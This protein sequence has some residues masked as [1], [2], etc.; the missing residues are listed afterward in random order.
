MRGPRAE[1]PPLIRVLLGNLQMERAHIEF[2][3]KFY[4]VN[5]QDDGV[6][7]GSHNQ[8]LVLRI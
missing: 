7:G 1:K 2:G 3:K 5:K 4:I 6:E 8:C